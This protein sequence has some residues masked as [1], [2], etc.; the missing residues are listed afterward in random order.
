MVYF[1]QTDEWDWR[2][3]EVPCEVVCSNYSSPA[4]RL[5]F[6]PSCCCV[7]SAVRATVQDKRTVAFSTEKFIC[8]VFSVLPGNQHL[9]TK[10]CHAAKLHDSLMHQRMLPTENVSYICYI[11]FYLRNLQIFT[12]NGFPFFQ[13]N[14][15]KV[16][17]FPFWYQWSYTAL[18]LLSYFTIYFSSL[19]S[20]F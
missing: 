18:V 5:W 8:F 1:A 13:L 20:L 3:I 16:S 19:W 11:F 2:Q 15:K 7:F 4:D 6:L 10:M 9:I 14:Y 17:A 12:S